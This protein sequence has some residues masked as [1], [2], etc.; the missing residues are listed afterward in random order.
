MEQ[1]TNSRS[2]LTNMWP[3][4]FDKD[5]KTSFSLEKRWS[6]QKMLLK[7]LCILPQKRKSLNPYLTLHIKINSKWTINIKPKYKTLRKKSL[8]DLGL[9]KFI[10]AITLKA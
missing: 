2:K 10:L 7:Q 8:C 3:A 6:F 9:G 5:A 4:D 1:N